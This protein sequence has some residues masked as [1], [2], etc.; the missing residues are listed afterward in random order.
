VSLINAVIEAST[1]IAARCT[2]HEPPISSRFTDQA[3]A[4]LQ[5]VPADEKPLQ[6]LVKAWAANS[7]HGLYPLLA[8][9]MLQLYTKIFGQE[10]TL[11]VQDGLHHALE[12]LKGEARKYRNIHTIRYF[13]AEKPALAAQPLSAF[14]AID[15]NTDLQDAFTAVPGDRNFHCFWAEV[16]ER[17][18]VKRFRGQI[19]AG[20]LKSD[21]LG[22]TIWFRETPLLTRTGSKT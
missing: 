21:L 2:Q 22:G 19:E 16:L 13:V 12:N 10:D 14:I 9:V 15:C 4:F 18:H 17:H 6:G 11:A 3:A 20:E 1:A 7:S 8:T 5:N